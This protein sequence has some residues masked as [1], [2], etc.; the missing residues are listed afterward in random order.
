MNLRKK[1]LTAVALNEDSISAAH[2]ANRNLW[3]ECAQGRYQIV[4]CS[5]EQLNSTKMRDLIDDKAFQSCVSMVAVDEAHLIP[6]WGGDSHGPA[7]RSAF[8]TIGTLRTRFHSSVVF[9]AVSGTLMPGKPT[10]IVKERLGFDGPRFSFIQRDCERTNLHI[11]VR[12]LQHP[13]TQDSFADLDW[14]IP[15]NIS[16]AADIPKTIVYIDLVA[17]GHTL[18]T[19]LRSLLPPA[20][21]SN[22]RLSIRHLYAST[23]VQCKDE[24]ATEFLKLGED[25]SIRIV[26]ATEA[27]GCGVDIRDV[28]RVVNLGT[29]QDLSTLCQRFGRTGRGLQVGYCYVYVYPKLWDA[30]LKDLGLLERSRSKSQKTGEGSTEVANRETTKTECCEYFKQILVSHLQKQCINRRINIIYGNPLENK[31]NPCAR[32][33][34]CVEDK[35]LPP[36]SIKRSNVRAQVISTGDEHS[37][38][39]QPEPIPPLILDGLDLPSKATLERVRLLIANAAQDIWLSVPAHKSTKQFGGVHTFLPITKS[40]LLSTRLLDLETPELIRRALGVDWGFWETHGEGLAARVLSIRTDLITELR[41]NQQ[42]AMSK[43]GAKRLARK[44]E[45]DLEDDPGVE[46]EDLEAS[47]PNKA[48]SESQSVVVSL[49]HSRISK[50]QRL[51][52]GDGE[53]K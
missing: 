22:A 39:N 5:P 21:R 40:S 27:F 11:T 25:S 4:L 24:V 9:A 19:Y 13:Y 47:Q 3:V 48:I 43:R 50:R 35:I 14:L 34:G 44:A 53:N 38:P 41:Q 12:R 28:F 17:R 26:V 30:V 29:P 7:F 46:S 33:S 42:T 37:Q 18:V 45:M 20:L 15:D 10:E 32:C 6:A 8:N 1:G 23:C 16:C 31:P 52:R 2:E 36:R 49:P 51:T